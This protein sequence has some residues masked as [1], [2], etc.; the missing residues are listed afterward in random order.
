MLKIRPA[1]L[2]ALLLILSQWTFAVQNF[3]AIQ[4]QAV[5]SNDTYLAADEIEASLLEQGQVYVHQAV[6]Q[7]IQVRYFL[8][9]SN[10]AQ[11]VG[12]RGTANLTNAMLDLDV[13]L[14]LDTQLNIKLHN[15]FSSSAKAVYRDIK[16]YLVA[17]KPIHLTGHSLGGAIAVVLAMYL[18]QDGFDVTQ[19]ITFGQPK[20]TNVAGAA[21]FT[22]L[23]LIRV[24]T[25]NDIV[26]LVPPLSPLQIK[27][28]DIYWHMGVEVILMGNGEYAETS[29][30]KSALRATKFTTSI[31]SEKNLNAHKMTTYMTLISKLKESSLE[32]PYEMEIGFFGFS[33]N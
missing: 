23:P 21:K 33:I 12:V 3:L 25:P 10:D 28:L 2:S 30:V 14:Q 16:P 32:V 19:V 27:E 15:G 29:G 20:V 17:D 8:S 26:P 5:F 9:K 11:T 4:T 22:E 6:L 18:Q 24:V 1:I 7:D 13:A 31:P